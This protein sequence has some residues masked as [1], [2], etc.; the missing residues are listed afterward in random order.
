ILDPLFHL[1]DLCVLCGKALHQKSTEIR[2]HGLNC[3]TRP[4]LLAGGTP[5]TRSSASTPY[6]KAKGKDKQFDAAKKLKKVKLN[7]NKRAMIYTL[8]GPAFSYA[9]AGGVGLLIGAAR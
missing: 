9:G 7:R 8:S 3:Q 1:C 2:L 5:P 6:G 4:S